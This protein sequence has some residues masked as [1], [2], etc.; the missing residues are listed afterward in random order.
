MYIIIIISLAKSD[1]GV[2]IHFHRDHCV[3]K[4]AI[5]HPFGGTVLHQNSIQSAATTFE[6]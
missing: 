1:Q 6:V 2:I 3:T 5:K 4:S